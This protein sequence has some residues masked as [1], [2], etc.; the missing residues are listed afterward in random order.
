[1]SSD[2]QSEVLNSAAGLGAI[3]PRRAIGVAGTDRASYLQGLLTN[4]I[5][6]LTPGTGCYAAWLT[7]QGRMLTDL[8]VL[9]SGDMILLDVPIGQHTATLARL[10][11]FLFSED[12]QLSDLADTLVPVWIHG[13][14][15]AAAV[16][17]VTE[18]LSAVAN[19][20]AYQNART[21]VG[22]AAVV[23]ARIDQLGV[24]GFCLYAEASRA[25]HVSMALEQAGAV[26]LSAETL[27]GMR[28]DAGYPLFGLDMS[29]DTIPLEAGIEAR[30]ISLT[31]G[32]Y[33][34]QEIIIR[35]L[36][37]GHGRVAR[38]LVSLSIDDGVPARGA[39][40][41]AGEKQIGSVTSAA[42]SFR[43]GPVAM[44]YL[45]RDYLTPG[46]VVDVDV[47]GHRCA[48]RVTAVAG[49]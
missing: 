23:V 16:Q 14:A 8:H 18:G 12:V 33:V 3:E 11:Q 49:S 21:Q 13:V 31:K 5:L 36:H 35:V 9:E 46:T 24:P 10:D 22:D 48:A 28:I 34:G 15:A 45:H 47:D 26:P 41:F 43:R 2:E 1:M 32:C 29:T 17:K 38:K 19:W 25:P 39:A 20:T 30:A 6:A 40:L 7:A 4:D 42:R 44:G 37:R 27:E